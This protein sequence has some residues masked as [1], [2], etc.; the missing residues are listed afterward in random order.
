METKMGYTEHRDLAMKLWAQ[1]VG[2]I[3]AEARCREEADRFS[4][5]EG[6]EEATR[7][8]RLTDEADEHYRR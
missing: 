2:E 4:D 3:D 8:C 1:A 5:C 7:F 6:Y